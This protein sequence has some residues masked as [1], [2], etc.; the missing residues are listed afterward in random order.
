MSAPIRMAIAGYGYIAHAHAKAA[1][2]ADGVS[3]VGVMGRDGDK[4]AEFART[5][6]LAKTMTSEEELLTDDEIDA[7]VS[8]AVASAL[9]FV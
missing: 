5:Y 7:V 8:V 3:L 1:Q 9:A 2:G 6:A 4:G